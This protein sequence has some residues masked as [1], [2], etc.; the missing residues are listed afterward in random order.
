[1]FQKQAFYF[2]QKLQFSSKTDPQPLHGA[3]SV[4]VGALPVPCLALIPPLSF[5]DGIVITA[6]Y[7]N[8]HGRSA[9]NNIPLHW[10]Q[11]LLKKK[12]KIKSASS[13]CRHMQSGLAL[14]NNNS[15][16]SVY[17]LSSTWKGRYIEKVLDSERGTFPKM[18]AW[19]WIQT[20]A[21]QMHLPLK[22]GRIVIGWRL[23]RWTCYI[24]MN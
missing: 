8:R 15:L 5:C 21:L 3:S 2:E 19:E 9:R 4:R 17:W 14:D 10:I 6:K 22:K 23:N 7:Y 16:L 1:M 13:P 18:N 11:M 12:T 24:A 20:Y